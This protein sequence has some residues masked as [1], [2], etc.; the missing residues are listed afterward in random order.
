MINVLI[1]KTHVINGLE[2]WRP[3]PI[4][5]IWSGNSHLMETNTTFPGLESLLYCSSFLSC[6]PYHHV[7]LLGQRKN[8]NWRIV[9]VR[10]LRR[11][12]GLLTPPS[13]QGTNSSWLLLPVGLRNSTTISLNESMTQCWWWIIMNYFFWVWAYS[14]SWWVT[15]LG[16]YAMWVGTS[17]SSTELEFCEYAR[18]EPV[19]LVLHPRFNAP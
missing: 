2:S 14:S 5:G 16:I 7:F 1:R 17:C 10:N 12:P 3:N 11:G 4:Q 9:G 15:F 18:A 19:L 6:Y 13:T 8:P